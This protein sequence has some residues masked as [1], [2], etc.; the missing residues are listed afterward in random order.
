ML[1]S[2]LYANGNLPPHRSLTYRIHKWSWQDDRLSQVLKIVRILHILLIGALVISII[3]GTEMS[4]GDSD[5]NQGY[6]LRRV[7]GI[8]FIIAIIIMSMVVLGLASLSRPDGWRDPQLFQIF[9][10]LPIIF[11]RTVYST[12]QAFISTPSSPGYNI[13]VYLILL[14]IP[15]LIST[16]I[17]VWYGLK[18]IPPSPL[19]DAAP[20]GSSFRSPKNGQG[21]QYPGV[22]GRLT[23]LG[24]QQIQKL[25]AAHLPYQYVR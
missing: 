5:I 21:R 14:Q 25:E 22:V 12:V 4:P 24:N 17:Y 20:D 2:R 9:I 23:E 6:T 11:F 7:G 19:L 16:S 18:M 8:L 13:W 3:G 10:V 1:L 15:D